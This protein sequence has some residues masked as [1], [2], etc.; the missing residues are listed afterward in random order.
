MGV[1]DGSWGRGLGGGG[2][3]ETEGCGYRVVAI[4]WVEAV[5]FA[6]LPADRGRSGFQV[7]RRC[8]A[9]GRS[10]MGIASHGRT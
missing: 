8:K 5:L 4:M 6:V 3:C 9:C 1:F 10:V 7:P 2:I